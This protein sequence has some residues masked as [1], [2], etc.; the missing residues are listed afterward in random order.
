[1]KF[2]NLTSS[3]YI[4][5]PIDLVTVSTP[6]INVAAMSDK[7]DSVNTILF[8]E[9][10][11][12]FKVASFKKWFLLTFNMVFLQEIDILLFI[13]LYYYYFLDYMWW[14]NSCFIKLEWNS[15]AKNYSS[16]VFTNYVIRI[17][18]WKN[19]FHI[20]ITWQKAK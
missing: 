8:Y 2:C 5:I 15:E 1:M 9:F 10:S 19:V 4:Q 17:A 6:T 12:L 18:V 14:N 11:S 13:S 16:G 3:F 20:T 7:N